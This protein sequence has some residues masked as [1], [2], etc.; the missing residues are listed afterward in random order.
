MMVHE[1]VIGTEDQGMP[2]TGPKS[3][4]AEGSENLSHLWSITLLITIYC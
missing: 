1:E 3:H 2:E 4:I